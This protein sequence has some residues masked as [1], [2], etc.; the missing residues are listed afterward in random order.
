MRRVPLSPGQEEGTRSGLGR[1]LKDDDGDDGFDVTDELDVSET[2]M[3]K[4]AADI[5]MPEP[6]VSQPCN[7]K[8][9]A[10][11]LHY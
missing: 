3:S 10:Q 8:R 7:F 1:P 2:G 4:L 9:P 11:K 6:E 5:E